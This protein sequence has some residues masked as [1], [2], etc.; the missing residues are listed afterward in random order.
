MTDQLFA[1]PSVAP[2]L[3]PAERVGRWVLHRAGII[4]VWQYDR[5]E[6]EFG[7][8][9]ALLRG[10]NGAGKS[11]ALEVLLPFVLDGDARAID[12]AGRDR[13]TVYWLMTD[14]REAG[15]HVGY[16]WLELRM[17]TED[18]E[19]RFCTLGAGLKASPSTRQT[20]T[21]W[22]MTEDAR[23]GVDL[24][25]N[26][27]VSAEKLRERLGSDAVTTAAE[28]RRRV[29]QRLFGLHDEARY[30]NLLHLL[31]R[32]RDPNIGNKIEAGELAA[33]LRD[34][35][36]PP[37]DHTIENAAQRFDDLDQVKAQLDRTQRTAE[38]LKRFLDTYRG[39]ARTVVRDRTERVLD[40]V[41][42]QRRR[43]RKAKQTA[44]ENVAATTARQVADAKVSGLQD[45]ES[46]A[47]REL[48]GL[49]ASDAYK[50][51]Q[52]LAD[53]RHA[54]EAKQASARSAEQAATDLQ[55]VADEAVADE[56]EA[57]QRAAQ[58]EAAVTSARPPLLR[59][60]REAAVDQA[61][62]PVDADGIAHAVTVADGRR[63][64]AEQ[65]RVLA[66][67]AREAKTEAGRADERAARS[68]QELAATEADA[69]HA[70][71]DW[72]AQSIAWRTAVTAWPGDLGAGL[73]L[74]NWEPLHRALGDGPAGMEELSSAR[75]LAA[76]S[77]EPVREEARDRESLARTALSTAEQTLRD[78]ELERA[79]LEAEEEA[80]PPAS[81]FYVAGRDER[82]G[83]PLYELVDVGPGLPA[84]QRAGLEAALEASGLLDAWVD[85]DGLVVHPSTQDVIV[86][87]DAPAL[88]DGVATLAEVL[89]AT[90]PHVQRVLQAIGLG[91][92]GDAP[93]V[94]LDGRWSLGP[95]CGAWTK[96]ES[97]YLGAGTRRETRARR[98]AALV[99]QCDELRIAVGLSRH[100][101]DDARVVRERLE[102]LTATFPEDASVRDAWSR[103]EARAG[104]AGAARARFGSDRRAAERARTAAAQAVTELEH[105]AAAE[106]LP[107][108][109]AALQAVAT[110][111][112]ELSRELRS[113]A[114]AW[115]ALAERRVEAVR[116]GEQRAQ[117]AASAAIAAERMEAL[118]RECEDAAAQLAALEDAVGATVA[119][120][121][122]AIGECERARDGA[123]AALPRAQARAGDAAEAVGRA[124]T[125]LEAA[126]ASVASAE[127]AVAAAGAQLGRA[128]VL[129]GL[130]AAAID[131]EWEWSP[132]DV[133]AAA[134]TVRGLV[135]SDEA[136]VTDQVVLNRLHDLE[137]GLAGGYDVAIGEEEGVKFF[138]VT[139]DTGR[140]P[141]PAVTARVVAEA[142]AAAARLAANEREI[143]ERFLLGELGEELR[144]RLMEADD[145]VTAAN[146]ALDGVRTSHGK[147]VHL[148]WRIDQEAPAVARST[149]DLL[150][151]S[152]RSPEE[153]AA[154]RD[155]LMDLIRAEREKDPALG[156]MEHLRAAL[157]YRR[158]YRF[159]VLVV[160]DARP[161]SQRALSSRL[162]LSQ[163][164]QRV[165][166]YLALFA[167]ASAHYEGLGAECPR[168]LLLDD[169]FAKVDEPTHG[170]LLA[171]LVELNLDFMLTSERM[172]GCFPEV[173]SLEIYE[174][175]REPSVPGVALVH[176]RWDGRQRHL[177]G[178]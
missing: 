38:A 125:A 100:A 172:W 9:R 119:E 37:S 126:T 98:L 108:S 69:D 81:R 107:S 59:L 3:R 36:P 134:R 97:E 176:F 46:R 31:H 131:T 26:P 165:L 168:L 122:T 170:R 137:T 109:V 155:A 89:V 76:S 145:L 149:T 16:L 128:I 158:W 13:T 85:D 171:L 80:R 40:A 54:V 4:N 55:R 144:E 65:I 116:K 121:L 84:N 48:E 22:F 146:R 82:A 1:T 157:D 93:W 72:V 15:N 43:E 29:A 10:K 83:A 58:A 113:W 63:R 67:T 91:D 19:D 118:R 173:P 49:R 88:P 117:R 104:V 28:H 47:V 20:T 66:E 51:H 133:E 53:R 135:G 161:G 169:A 42:E 152:P 106:S 92:Q 60:A 156:Y 114:G 123:R 111:A 5:A 14:G 167:A 6:I 73:P 124:A 138:H 115:D 78:K 178:L 96:T 153:D 150:R 35:L 11:K 44:E 136:P 101:A 142:E 132:V 86:R 2:P 34:A 17:T 130:S 12:A 140:Q 45:D 57:R 103:A 61:V 41:T 62:V 112:R 52:H 39:Y 74:P 174:A 120:V 30:A 27:E 99:R 102:N 127:S 143:I 94:G 160:D 90:R 139:D 8:G 23:V 162:G 95:L 56:D 166:S 163:G 154:L 177:V 141:L 175:L 32:L 129:P 87:T 71:D 75:A 64:A 50:D 70:R 105:A 79:T 164:E 25:L 24:H 77:L 68:E 148:E 151:R 159:A 18:G 21:W 110:A 33:V 7:G 147:G